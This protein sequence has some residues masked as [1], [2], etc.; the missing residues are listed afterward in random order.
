MKTKVPLRPQFSWEMCKHSFTCTVK[1]TFYTNPSRKRSFRIERP[2]QT[3]GGTDL[4]TPAMRA[5]QYE[6]ASDDV[7]IITIMSE[8]SSTPNP[9]WLVIIAFLNF[10]DVVWTENVWCVFRVKIPFSSSALVHWGGDLKPVDSFT[11]VR[12]LKKKRNYNYEGCWFS[13]IL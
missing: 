11:Q 13:A 4:K 5:F 12:I 2:L 10:F 9:K 3:G 1:S 7:T 8:F 6:V